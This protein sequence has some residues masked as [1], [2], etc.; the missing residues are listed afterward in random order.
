MSAIPPRPAFRD[1]AVL[2]RFYE[3]FAQF[4]V[5]MKLLMVRNME[6]ALIIRGLR[7][8]GPPASDGY[9]YAKQ[10][11]AAGWDGIDSDT[12]EYLSDAWSIWSNAHLA[13]QREWISTFNVQPPFPSGTHVR[14][15][16]TRLLLD[17]RG[18]RVTTTGFAYFDDDHADAG[19]C[20]FRDEQWIAA[21]GDQGGYVLNWED[22]TA[23]SIPR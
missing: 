17:G 19:Q 3:D 15:E 14:A 7:A 4:L 18:Q 8:A 11:E 1:I 9:T 21:H 22:L 5:D 20:L 2:D 10:L 16:V 6:H 12:I 23:A 13:H